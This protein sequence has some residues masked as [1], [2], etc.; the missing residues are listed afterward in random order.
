MTSLRGVAAL[1]VALAHFMGVAVLHRQYLWVD[2]F[3]ILSGFILTHAYRRLFGTKLT[4]HALKVFF[5]ARFF[6]I[7]PLHYA[8]LLALIVLELMKLAMDRPAFTGSNSLPMLGASI[9]LLQNW[10][11]D[12]GY[13]WN[14]PAW[15]ISV[16][17]AAYLLFPFLLLFAFRK[18]IVTIGLMLTSI[19]CL[20]WRWRIEGGVMESPDVFRCVCEFFIG[21]AIYRAGPLITV[22]GR[23]AALQILV[24]ICLGAVF[25]TAVPDFFAIPLFAV[26]IGTL[27]TDRGV[28]ADFLKARP[29]RFLGLVSYSIYLVHFAVYQ[30]FFLVDHR[31][32]HD[33]M[34]KGDVLTK[35]GFAAF[36]MP[37][38][39]MVASVTYFFVEVPCREWG[40]RRFVRLK[41]VTA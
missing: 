37:F 32:L 3:F 20:L 18:R 8:M 41:Q 39:V 27:G 29:L 7:F 11:P 4:G 12:I 2:F 13:S 40:A 30:F 15:S 35:W 10:L 19:V 33:M 9:L 24:F 16:E 17:M 34:I 38:V 25:V 23:A 21:M 1:G 36:M 6:R 28:V 31:L 26:L 22:A 5:K 14:M